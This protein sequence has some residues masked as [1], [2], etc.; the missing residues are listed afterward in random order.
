[1]A[2]K[3]KKSQGV[4]ERKTGGRPSGP[5]AGKPWRD[6]LRLTALQLV[7]D[8]RKGKTKLEA[9]AIALFRAAVS[10]DVPALKEIGDRLDGKV[11]Q[12]VVGG[13]EDDNPVR[14]ITE[15]RRTIVDPKR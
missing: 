8:D 5:W 3:A 12:A 10:G 9:A 1:M 15:I 4:S 6:A 14:V 13:S 7:D 2:E 11:P